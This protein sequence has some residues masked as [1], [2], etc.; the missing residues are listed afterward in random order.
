MTFDDEKLNSN[1]ACHV[2]DNQI[3]FTTSRHTVMIWD[4]KW[5]VSSAREVELEGLHTPVGLA[6]LD[7]KLYVACFG[8]WTTCPAD[9]PLL[10]S[11]LAVIDLADFKVE[12]FGYD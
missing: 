6:Y 9:G 7:H 5:D 2:N 10:N 1:W 3:A 4:P 11:G 8:G 12:A